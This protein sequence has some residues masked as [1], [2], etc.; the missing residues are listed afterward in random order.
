MSSETKKNKVLIAKVLS[1]KMNK[2]AVVVVERQVKHPINGKYIKR[3]TKLHIHDEQNECQIG[4]KVKIHQ[5][6]PI[7]KTKA[8][9]LFKE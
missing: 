5:S 4:Q 8:W 6:K 9:T 7:S 1:N 2:S 3:S